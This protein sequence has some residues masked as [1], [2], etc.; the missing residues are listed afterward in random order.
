MSDTPS[1]APAPDDNDS[2]RSASL[3]VYVIPGLSL[4]I[5]VFGILFLDTF[6]WKTHVADRWIPESCHVPMRIFFFSIAADLPLAGLVARRYADDPLSR[7]IE[8]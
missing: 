1:D 3:A 2:P 4:Y 7:S 8:R 5:G 6:V